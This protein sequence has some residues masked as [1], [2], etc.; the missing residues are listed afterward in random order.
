M[1]NTHIN[2]KTLSWKPKLVWVSRIRYLCYCMCF[3]LHL[4]VLIKNPFEE[5]N[6]TGLNATFGIITILTSRGCLCGLD[7]TCVDHVT[8]GDLKSDFFC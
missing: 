1:E 7:H 4:F 3:T 8:V 6:S 2:T 5:I